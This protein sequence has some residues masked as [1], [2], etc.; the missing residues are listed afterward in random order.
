MLQQWMFSIIYFILQWRFDDIMSPS[1]L[2]GHFPVSNEENQSDVKSSNFKDYLYNHEKDILS[3]KM[4]FSKSGHK[5]IQ[6]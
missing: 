4:F 3:K 1:S 6:P 5:H 2:V